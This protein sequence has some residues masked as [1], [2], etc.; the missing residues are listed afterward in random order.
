M[1]PTRKSQA[2]RR[3]RLTR[4]NTEFPW[5]ALVYDAF[6]EANPLTALGK[7]NLAERAIS[8]RLCSPVPLVLR[9]HVALTDALWALRRWLEVQRRVKETKLELVYSAPRRTLCG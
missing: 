5:Q 7:I 8:S 9:E 2:E 4:H 1:R 6:V 3:S